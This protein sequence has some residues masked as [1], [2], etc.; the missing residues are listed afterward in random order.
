MEI[1]Q[2]RGAASPRT[3]RLRFP[4]RH[5]QPRDGVEPAPRHR[6]VRRRVAGLLVDEVDVRSTNIHEVRQRPHVAVHA[7]A[8]E[9]NRTRPAPR[10]RD[11]RLAVAVARFRLGHE[12]PQRV[13]AVGA[14][15]AKIIRS[16]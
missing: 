12:S 10:Q 3:R 4:H 13:Y 15:R 11:E 9:R 8:L 2:C 16:R 7:R 1:N 5:Q 6:D 14:A